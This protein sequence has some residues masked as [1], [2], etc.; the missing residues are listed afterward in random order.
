MQGRGAGERLGGGQAGGAVRLERVGVR[1]LGHG[2]L[3]GWRRAVGRRRER[4][5]NAASSR[6][7]AGRT[8]EKADITH[9]EIGRRGRDGGGRRPRGGPA[10]AER[11]GTGRPRRTIGRIRAT[12]S[13]RSG[14][15]RP[16]VRT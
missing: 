16:N 5:G 6:V 11:G 14:P 7:P 9:S 4:E 12:R 10:G 15:Q 13:F 3:R 1:A 8:T 2:V